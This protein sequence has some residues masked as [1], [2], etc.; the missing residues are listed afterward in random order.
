[1]E[2]GYVRERGGGGDH[3]GGE[4]GWREGGRQAGRK[5]AG[6]GGRKGEGWHHLV[7]RRYSL[8]VSS[9]ETAHLFPLIRLL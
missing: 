2:R 1:M 6:K 7:E 4:G 9:F 8:L 3:K 5:K